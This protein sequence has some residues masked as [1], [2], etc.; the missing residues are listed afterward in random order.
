MTRSARKRD[1]AQRLCDS[2]FHSFQLFLR[3]R[4]S[5]C[6]FDQVIQQNFAAASFAAGRECF[7]RELALQFRSGSAVVDGMRSAHEQVVA[8]EPRDVGG[9]RGIAKFLPSHVNEPPDIER[10]GDTFRDCAELHR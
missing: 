5:F 2:R 1:V 3:H 6:F 10:E 4:L 8:N 9:E 7:A